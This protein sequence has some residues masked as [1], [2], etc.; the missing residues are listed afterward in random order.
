[1]CAR[2]PENIA[3]FLRSTSS[4]PRTTLRSA[5]ERLTS[6]FDSRRNQEVKSRRRRSEGR[7]QPPPTS[8]IAELRRDARLRRAEEDN[9]KVEGRTTTYIL[10]P[11]APAGA[12]A[13]LG[14]V[15]RM[16][17]SRLIPVLA[18]VVGV[19]L[20]IQGLLGLLTP[21][22]FVAFVRLFQ[23]PSMVHIAGVLRIAIGIVLLCAATRS[24]LPMFLR[25]F[26]VLIVIGG[27]LTP[28]VG[29]RFAHT[30]LALWSSRGPAL[31]R[32]FALVSLVLGLLT[33]Y[34]VSPTR[35]HA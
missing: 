30:I 13:E 1:M 19:L 3:V 28:F 35:R 4:R 11:L 20:I 12:A 2:A 24:R 21:D 23:P 18:L 25:I 27:V 31:V 5:L 10:L 7:R 34:A 17:A 8:S 26:G 15:R 32:L 6:K 22:T 33:S 16:S 14:L 29:V 9:E